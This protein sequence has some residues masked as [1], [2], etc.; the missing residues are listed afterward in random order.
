VSWTIS[1]S[2]QGPVRRDVDQLGDC[3][4]VHSGAGRW[5]PAKIQNQ[6]RKALQSA[7]VVGVY[8]GEAGERLRAIHRAMTVD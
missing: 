6:N 8:H 7:G 3:G 4:W 5:I 1:W 2:Q